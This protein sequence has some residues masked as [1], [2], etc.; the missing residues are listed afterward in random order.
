M[1]GIDW[2]VQ[3]KIFFP[4]GFQSG[5][6]KL[7][8]STSHVSSSSLHQLSVHSNQMEP[9]PHQP[10]VTL[11]MKQKAKRCPEIKAKWQ[12]C[13]KMMV[14]RYPEIKSQM[15]LW[16]KKDVQLE[17]CKLSFIWGKMRTAAWEAASQM[18]LR[19]YSQVAVG[20]R[21]YIRFWWRGSWIPWSTRFIKGFLLVM[22]I[23]CH[24]EGI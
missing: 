8:V 3:K 17:S 23:W 4:K 9:K 2:P 16:T 21:Q 24:H 18:A 1:I 13:S 5:V 7:R 20:E 19:D 11:Q 12:E 6:W 15:S 22:R 10:G 14:T